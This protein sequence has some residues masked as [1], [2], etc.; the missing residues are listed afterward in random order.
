MGRE[1]GIIVAVL[2]CLVVA[3]SILG[4]SLVVGRMTV[5]AA[6]KGWLPGFF[7]VVGRVGLTSARDVDEEGR[8]VENRRDAPINAIILNIIVSAVYIFVG[9]F[10]AL[11]TFNGLGE[12]A[13]F[14][15]AVLGA[16]I[17]RFREPQLRRPHKPF[18]LIPII[19]AL[20]SGFVVVRGA[21]FAPIQSIILVGLWTVGLIFYFVRKRW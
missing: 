10:R 2:I 1:F 3:G 9:S 5:S 20:V 13:F 11:L 12:Y 16:I 19:F 15:L 4:N 18:I 8:P 17:L 14:F 7:S 6:N 21:V